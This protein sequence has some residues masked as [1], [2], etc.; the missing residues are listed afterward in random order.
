V[1]ATVGAATYWDA[2]AI[3]SALIPDAHS[4]EARTH[5]KKGGTHVVSSLAWVETLAVL[6]RMQR[7][8]MLSSTSSESAHKTLSRAPWRPVTAA[9]R[10]EVVR[11]LAA[12]WKLKGAD[13]WH[14]AAAKH[15]Q[16]DLPELRLLSFDARLRLAAQG[17][18]LA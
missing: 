13:L 18:G 12:A 14:L 7:E 8:G 4:D 10:W 16:E 6:A 3:L 1:P 9:P 2:S 11:G 15:L 5:A 17:E